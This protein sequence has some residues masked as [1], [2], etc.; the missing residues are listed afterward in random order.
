LTEAIATYQSIGD[1][2]REARAVASL[3]TT[4]GM[5]GDVPSSTVVDLAMHA[6]TLAESVGDVASAAVALVRAGITH[7]EDGRAADAG[8]V[9][10]R[11]LTLASR[12]QNGSAISDAT[13]ILG[14][15]RFTQRRWMEAHELFRSLSTRGTAA[16]FMPQ[17]WEARTNLALGRF[18]DARDILERARGNADR[19][20]DATMRAVATFW[21]GE[22]ARASGDRDGAANAYRDALV[23]IDAPDALGHFSRAHLGLAILADEAGDATG[24]R[25]HLLAATGAPDHTLGLQLPEILAAVARIAARHDPARARLAWASA[26]AIMEEARTNPVIPHDEARVVAI[27]DGVRTPLDIADALIPP[28]DNASVLALARQVAADLPR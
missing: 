4:H 21:V 3:A 15:S 8:Q 24:A 25:H 20:G 27:I 17:V 2:R 14:I 16:A 1:R 11:A 19:L 18:N 6:A 28:T 26:Q 5:V 22:V 23:T 10:E 12:A 9:L 13:S 7:L